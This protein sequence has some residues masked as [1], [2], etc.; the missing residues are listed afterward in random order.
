VV[1]DEA[2]RLV[3]QLR[4]LPHRTIALHELSQQTPANWMR[5]KTHEA[6]RFTAAGGNR[7][8][9]ESEPTD[10]ADNPSN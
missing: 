7:G 1:R 10:A 6:R 5:D 9:H 4:Q 8:L 3:D 2:L